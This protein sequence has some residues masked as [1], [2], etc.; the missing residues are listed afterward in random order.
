MCPKPCKWT[1][2]NN[3]QPQLVNARVLNHQ[4]YEKKGV[5]TTSNLQWLGLPS[6]GA[7]RLLPGAYGW[8]ARGRELM[9]DSTCLRLE[10]CVSLSFSLIL[11]LYLCYLR[12]FNL[13]TWY[14]GACRGWCRARHG[15]TNIHAWHG[16][17][18]RCIRLHTK[19][20]GHLHK[21]LALL[22]YCYMTN[23][24]KLQVSKL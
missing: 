24:E 5:I 18:L 3:Y 11:V 22:V 14:L 21:A 8:H 19:T 16:R 12:P 13:K 6:T 15:S 20:E 2:I 9:A 1:G 23:R 7:G 10:V 17:T 4:R